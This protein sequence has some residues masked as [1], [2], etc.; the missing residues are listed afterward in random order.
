MAKEE[1]RIKQCSELGPEPDGVS[2]SPSSTVLPRVRRE[3]NQ[4]HLNNLHEAVRESL[5]LQD[6][7]LV[8]C[9]LIS[10]RDKGGY[11]PKRLA[12]II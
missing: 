6:R 10:R 12:P 1:G 4:M 11:P 2:L 5:T 3:T 9:P 7:N 8:T